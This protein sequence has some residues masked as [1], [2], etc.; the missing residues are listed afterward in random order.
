MLL[1]Q[2]QTCLIHRSS[3]RPWLPCTTSARRCAAGLPVRCRLGGIS[4]PPGIAKR[5]PDAAFEGHRHRAVVRAHLLSAE[6]L[7]ELVDSGV[8]RYGFVLEDAPPVIARYSHLLELQHFFPVKPAIGAPDQGAVIVL[9]VSETRTRVLEPGGFSAGEVGVPD[10]GLAVPRGRGEHELTGL[11]GGKQPFM[12]TGG[13]RLLRRKRVV[14][15][16]ELIQPALRVGEEL[17][18]K[19]VLRLSAP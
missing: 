9:L 5:K 18:A 10:Q 1:F 19:A 3:R 16:L 11:A 4:T 17:H 7:L 13:D 2:W 12:I 15:R 8:F 14:E 6:V